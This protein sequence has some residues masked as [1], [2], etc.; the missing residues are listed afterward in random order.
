M[1][2]F[3]QGA[4][5]AAGLRVNHVDGRVGRADDTCP[6]T[7]EHRT[8]SAT[9]MPEGIHLSPEAPQEDSELITVVLADDH[10][11]VR[12]GIR[13]VLEDEED[14]E[15]VAEA[16][17]VA[18]AERRVLGHHPK[19]LVLDLNMPGERSLPAIPQ[20]IERSPETSIFVLTMQNEPAFAREA[21]RAGARGFVVK[22]AAGRELVQA[23]REVANGGTYINPQL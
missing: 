10:E 2:G 7:R 23:I 21:L 8:M 20:I 9:R 19:V 5:P 13:M 18:S 1:R 11:I 16:G 17:D 12:D 22:H 4:Q 3:N 15:V 6:S 14:L